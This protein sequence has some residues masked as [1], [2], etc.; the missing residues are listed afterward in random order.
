MPLKPSKRWCNRG[1]K[2]GYGMDSFRHAGAG[3]AQLRA[4]PWG[5]IAA[6]K[7]RRALALQLRFASYFSH[8]LRS[9]RTLRDAGKALEQGLA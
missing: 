2:H 9:I 6:G 1:Y 4:M 8:L 7:K 3:H 5:W